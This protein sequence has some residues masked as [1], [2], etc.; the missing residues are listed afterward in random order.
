MDKTINLPF[1][2]DLN[3]HQIDADKLYRFICIKI[4]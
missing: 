4:I 2:L 1:N 3:T